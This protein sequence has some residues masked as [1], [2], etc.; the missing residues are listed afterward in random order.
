MKSILAI[1]VVAASA[2]IASANNNVTLFDADFTGSGGFTHTT[3]SPLPAAPNSV[4][5]NNF[6]LFYPSTI[7]TDTSE[8]FFRVNGGVLESS[9]FGGTH[10]LTSGVLDVSTFDLVTFT[11]TGETVGSDVFNNAGVEF[12]EGFYSLDGGSDVSVAN[13]TAD[14]DLS[15]TIDID[16]SAASTLEVGLLSN[17][18]GGGDGFEISSITVSGKPIPAPGAAALFGLAGLTA[19]RRRR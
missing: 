11:L 2:G 13:T 7:S 14:G 6:D 12:F 9:D 8:N 18:N 19:A 16:V 4:T 10:G 15:F 3:A 5:V 1:A 17:V